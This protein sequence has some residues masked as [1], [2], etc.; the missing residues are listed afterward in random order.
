MMRAIKMRLFGLGQTPVV[1]SDLF[2]KEGADL[3]HGVTLLWHMLPRSRSGANGAGASSGAAGDAVPVHKFRYRRRSGFML[4]SSN[5]NN[6]IDKKAEGVKKHVW[7]YFACDDDNVEIRGGRYS[8]VD[9]F[10]PEK[11]MRVE[12]QVQ[13]W[14]G[15]GAS[16][17]SKSEIC[18]VAGHGVGTDDDDGMSYSDKNRSVTVW[19]ILERVSAYLNTL[20]FIGQIILVL[21]TVA[22]SIAP[23]AVRVTLNTHIQRLPEIVA[24]TARK[25]WR[26]KRRLQD[27][28]CSQRCQR[29]IERCRNQSGPVEG[30]VRDAQSASPSVAGGAMA[31]TAAS[32]HMLETSRTRAGQESGLR[33]RRGSRSLSLSSSSSSN[34]GRDGTSSETVLDRITQETMATEQALSPGR[35]IHIRS[36]VTSKSCSFKFEDGQMCGVRSWWRGGRHHCMYCQQWYC[37]VHTGFANHSKFTS[38]NLA[39]ECVC[40]HCIANHPASPR[41]GKNRARSSGAGGRSSSLSFTSVG[42]ADSEALQSPATGLE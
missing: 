27:S 21:V 24:K 31:A 11:D 14:N 19:G 26:L 6:H 17:W 37:Q 22:L 29:G 34:D 7:E 13:A 15:Y 5:K 40:K 30:G 20:S 12:Y 33:S 23:P 41:H 18:F 28:P 9:A 2:C 10:V 36:K 25:A 38:C 42:S 35:S 8:S 16:E 1:A 39:T 3:G 32:V 4:T